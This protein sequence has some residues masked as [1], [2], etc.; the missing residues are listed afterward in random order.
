MKPIA[1]AT[2]STRWTI[3]GLLDTLL[4]KEKKLLDKARK[5]ER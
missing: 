3:L 4:N 1:L 5:E 2:S